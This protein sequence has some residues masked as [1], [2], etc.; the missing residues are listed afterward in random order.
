MKNTKN[1]TELLTSEL[2]SQISTDKTSRIIALKEMRENIK[3]R[4]LSEQEELARL[5]EERLELE[6]RI[7]VADANLSRLKSDK[8]KTAREIGKQKRLAKKITKLAT[9]DED[10][11]V[12]IAKFYPENKPKKR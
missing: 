1:N 12:D 2:F 5:V 11:Y 4:I 3:R 7:R 9:I 8:F 6:G 10:V